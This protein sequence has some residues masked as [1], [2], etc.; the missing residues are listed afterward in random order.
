MLTSGTLLKGVAEYQI[1]GGSS[2]N[3]F[4]CLLVDNFAE[5][6]TLWILFSRHYTNSAENMGAI[7]ITSRLCIIPTD[8]SKDYHQ[9]LTTL[10]S[11][12][13]LLR[14]HTSHVICKT[15]ARWLDPEWNTYYK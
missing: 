7:C 8:A 9:K 11:L 10:Y 6:L 14:K 1:E 15:V 12:T 2:V 3:Q 5:H 13:S 4:T